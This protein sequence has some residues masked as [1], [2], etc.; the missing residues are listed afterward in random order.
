MDLAQVTSTGVSISLGN[1]DG[2]FQPPVNYTAG[3]GGY[4]L[5]V[6]DFNLDGRL[7][8]ALSCEGSQA[9]VVLPGAGDGTLKTPQYYAAGNLPQF[10]IANDFNGDKKPD[11]AVVN[12]TS[13]DISIL[14]NN[15]PEP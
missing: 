10:L 4:A 1:G 2:T 7:D 8:V 12:Y 11:L 6:G 5:T 13:N 14:I 15:T 3:A 9:V